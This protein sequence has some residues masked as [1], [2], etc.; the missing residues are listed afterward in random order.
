MHIEVIEFASVKN[1]LRYLVKVDKGEGLRA[2]ESTVL[3]SCSK[4]V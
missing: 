1:H 3:F 2:S 4:P